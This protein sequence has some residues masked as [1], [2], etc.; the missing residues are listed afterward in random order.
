[1]TLEQLRRVRWPDVTSVHMDHLRKAFGGKCSKCGGRWSLIRKGRK[2][3]HR[4]LEFAHVKPTKL[5]GRGRGLKNRFFDILRNPDSYR[6]C[7]AL[8]DMEQLA[9]RLAA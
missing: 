7:H 2:Y 5:Q 9:R 3:R 1:M 8:F 4:P 6:L